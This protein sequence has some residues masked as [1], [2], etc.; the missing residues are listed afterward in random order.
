M[1][2]NLK[3]KI[4]K[5]SEGLLASLTDF[6]LSIFF[7]VS[8]SIDPKVAHSLPLAL[9]K[10]DKRMQKLNYQKIKRAI[11]YA[12]KKGWIKENLELTEEGQKRL[13]GLFP[14]F[15]KIP[16]WDGNWYLVN[17][18]IP[19]RLRQKRDIFRENLILLG[20]GKLQ[21]SV[22]ISPYNFLGDVEKIIKELNLSPYV[23]LAISDKVGRI[24]SKILAEKIWKVSE[25]QKDYREFISQFGE[26]ENPSPLEV[27]FKYHSIL[28]KDPRLPKELLPE[29][30][31]GEEA[32]RLYS[33][34]TK[35]FPFS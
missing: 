32:Y 35:K 13:K 6:V 30:W 26:K 34:I 20:F 19:E 10:V 1:E 31:A 14:E 24:E 23:I 7:F 9:A 27:F 21:N 29:D 28:R 2:R 3:E 4:L 15:S 17:F 5:I 22:W 12:Q 8:E 33:K 25:I 18:D 16:S 11:Q